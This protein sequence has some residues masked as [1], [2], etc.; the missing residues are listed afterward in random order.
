[1]ILGTHYRGDQ[2]FVDYTK[3]VPTA[4]PPGQT[5]PVGSE[6]MKTLEKDRGEEHATLQKTL[7]YG[8]K[9]NPANMQNGEGGVDPDLDAFSRR[10]TNVKQYVQPGEGNKLPPWAKEGVEPTD[11]QLCE[12]IEL[13]DETS[14]DILSERREMYVTGN[15]G[16]PKMYKVVRTH[17]SEKRL[18]PGSRS[19]VP[20]HHYNVVHRTSGE[21]IGKIKHEAGSKK[22]LENKMYN[23][24]RK[25]MGHSTT[26]RPQ[27]WKEQ[28]QNILNQETET[29]HEDVEAIFNGESL[30]DE[31]KT[32][33]STIFEAAV[34]S[35]VTSIAEQLEQIALEQLNE[36]VDT[37]KAELTDQ[38]D[39]YL[40]YMVE[41]W[42]KDNE[43]AVEKGL[44]SEIVEDFISGLRTLFVEHYID[45]PEDKV[46]LVSEL[47]D[48]VDE[49]TESLNDEITRGIELQ[50]ELGELKKSELL[51][52]A[53][54]G[55][56]QTQVEKVRTLAESV[57]FTTDSE[58]VTKIQT[59]KE[60]FFPTK[61]KS[62]GGDPLNENQL[63]TESY[64]DDNEK[65]VADPLM[66]NL[67]STISRLSK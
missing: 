53:C 50:K 26:G 13:D 55:L 20:V 59:L 44:R 16:R 32:K 40:N 21:V 67:V 5:P 41:E 8:G 66:R 33:A 48:K 42:I 29:L 47:A 54:E 2:P 57:E 49:L 28:I 56:T 62:N 10:Q 36:A 46:D 17:T 51:T 7:G 64:E 45:I 1:M 14:G 18:E 9:V 37:V 24:I 58:Y 15:K 25:H 65:V 43:I 60:N 22:E 6:P 35:R 11:D 12:V 34:T 27:S 61:I 38:V 23:V 31:F 4:T 30:S 39:D 19:M 52:V 3:G 63:I